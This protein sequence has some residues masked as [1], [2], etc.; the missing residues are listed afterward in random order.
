MLSSVSRTQLPL[1]EVL[2]QR[3]LRP[4]RDVSLANACCMTTVIRA[5][6]PPES[7]GSLAKKRRPEETAV[8]AMVVQALRAIL[9]ANGVQN[10]RRRLEVLVRQRID[11][12]VSVVPTFQ[13]D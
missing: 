5:G 13:F 4:A 10:R 1:A 2:V 8:L 11:Q 7:T 12:C 9:G 6:L 3:G